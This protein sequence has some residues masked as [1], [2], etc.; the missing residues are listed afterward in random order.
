MQL[1][2]RRFAFDPLLGI[3]LFKLQKTCLLV[4]AGVSP[5]SLVHDPDPPSTLQKVARELRV[6]PDNRWIHRVIAAASKLDT[7]RLEE[8]GVGTFV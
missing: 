3:A 6:D 4:A 1:A 8:L 2:K 7:R 5:L